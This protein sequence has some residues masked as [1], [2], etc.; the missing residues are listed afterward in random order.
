MET[1]VEKWVGRL[2]VMFMWED[3]VRFQERLEL[4]KQRQRNADDESRFL[5]YVENLS[6]KL[7]SPFS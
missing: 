5:H 3:P 4:S 7:S 6:D 1:G 2:S